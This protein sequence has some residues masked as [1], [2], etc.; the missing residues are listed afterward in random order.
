MSDDPFELGSEPATG[1]GPGGSES[2]ETDPRPNGGS[3]LPRPGGR[4]RSDGG[5]SL[6]PVSLALEQFRRDPALLLPFLVAGVCL[7]VLDWLRRLD[8]LPTRPAVQNG[9][10]ITIAYTGYPTGTPETARAL[11]SLVDLK[12][13]SLVWGIG[14]EAVAVLVIAAAGTVTIAR[15]LP[16][17]RGATTGRRLLAYG[18]LV[19]LF[20]G[21]FRVLASFIDGD[22]GLV[23]G[24]V[25]I[26]PLFA[27]FVRL[28]AAPAAV[29]TGSGP[30]TALR[31]SAPATR[32]HGW[33]ILALVIGF[34]LAAWLLG[35]VPRAGT[36]V[37]TALVGSLHA[38]TVAAL[39]EV[40]VEERARSG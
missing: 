36:V 15:A 21:A 28:F 37:S 13:P 4:D 17:D 27:V 30:V 11:E 39:W 10:S 33:T 20:D 18:G 12:L 9:V 31:Q 19:V 23:F 34:G 16:E 6:S 14:L 26:V 3:S 2:G 40:T 25:L 38:V 32:G 22:V 29:V 24:L 5:R 35:R 1:A 7:A 8:P